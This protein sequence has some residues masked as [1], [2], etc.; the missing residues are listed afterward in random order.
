MLLKGLFNLSLLALE[1]LSNYPI[2]LSLVQPTVSFWHL[3]NLSLLALE[4]LSNYP[5]L[6][7]LVQPTVSFWHLFNLSLLALEVLSNY[8]ILLSLVQPTV[9][10]WHLFNLSLLA[11]EVL[12]N[13]PILLSLVQPTVSFWHLIFFSELRLLTRS[14]T[15]YITSNIEDMIYNLYSYY[16]VVSFIL[17]LV[18]CE[19]AALVFCILL[20]S[21]LSKLGELRILARSTKAACICITGTSA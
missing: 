10:F 1:V 4:V 11:L 18:Q 12:S 13:Y 9:S 2:L 15:W 5:I 6:L 14:R 20:I 21:V 7:S 8:P 17:D 3:F 19:A 16:C